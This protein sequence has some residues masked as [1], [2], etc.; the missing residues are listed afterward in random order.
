MEHLP[1]EMKIQIGSPASLMDVIETKMDS[2]YEELKVPTDANLEQMK[3]CLGATEA[4]LWKRE[5]TP[6]EMEAVA[7]HQE[8]PK[9]P[10]ASRRS[11]HWMTDMGI[12]AWP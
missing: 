6:E 4:C 3:A 12:S 11:E 9:E 2:H 7:E 10:R 5:P 8:V 1:A